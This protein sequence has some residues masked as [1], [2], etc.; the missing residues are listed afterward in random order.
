MIRAIVASTISG[1]I[2]GLTRALMS[3]LLAAYAVPMP[4]DQTHHV[5]GFGIGGFFCGLLS[6]FLGVFM[7]I[8]REKKLAAA[9]A[10]PR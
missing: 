8:R 1:V 3:A 4:I 7:H 10:A 2:G 9:S 6:G 5:V